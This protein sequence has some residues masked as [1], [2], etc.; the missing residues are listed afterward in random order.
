LIFIVADENSAGSRTAWKEAQSRTKKGMD[1][2][3]KSDS[4]RI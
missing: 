4:E 1:M 3:W 2:G